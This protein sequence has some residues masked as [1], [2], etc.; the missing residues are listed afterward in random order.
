METPG[1]E[2]IVGSR[3]RSEL[4]VWEAVARGWV[5]GIA[6]LKAQSWSGGDRGGRWLRKSEEM[7]DHSLSSRDRVSGYNIQSQRT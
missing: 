5:Q 4:G 2:W 7:L 1:G 6:M 3:I